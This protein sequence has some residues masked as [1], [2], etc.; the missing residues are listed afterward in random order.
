MKRAKAKQVDID[1]EYMT[2]CIHLK[3]CRRLQKWNKKAGFTHG[4]GC[5]D[6][7]TTYLSGEL[8]YEGETLQEIIA[9][10]I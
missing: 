5:N 2:D 6:Y 9:Q 8:E 7:C 4:R 3:A 1:R 10:L